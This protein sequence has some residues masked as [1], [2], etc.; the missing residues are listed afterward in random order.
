MG[1]L[2]HTEFILIAGA[3]QSAAEYNWYGDNAISLS[4]ETELKE[5]VMWDCDFVHEIRVPGSILKA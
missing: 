3:T 4:N 2:D 5:E 1:T